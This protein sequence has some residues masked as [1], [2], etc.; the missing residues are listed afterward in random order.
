[1]LAIEPE[2]P[3]G[4]GVAAGRRG[5]LGGAARLGSRPES[6]LVF[7]HGPDYIVSRQFGYFQTPSTVA[8]VVWD[9]RVGAFLF[10]FDKVL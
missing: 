6:W 9:G 10:E 3:A 2:P 7:T 8:S 4:P 5:T 1:M